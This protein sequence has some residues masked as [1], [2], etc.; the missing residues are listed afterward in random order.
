[1]TS[2]T[3]GN[4]SMSLGYVSEILFVWDKIDLAQ[5]VQ[6]FLLGLAATLGPLVARKIWT[7]FSNKKQTPK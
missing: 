5:P 3:Q 4:L 7:Y 2:E 1:M 6:T